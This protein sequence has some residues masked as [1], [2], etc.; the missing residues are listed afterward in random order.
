M[1]SDSGDPPLSAGEN[2]ERNSSYKVRGVNSLSVY[3]FMCLSVF[4]LFQFLYS[5]NKGINDPVS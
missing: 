4:F 1:T 2:N 5:D 3:L